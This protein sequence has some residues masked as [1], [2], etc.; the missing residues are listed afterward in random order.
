MNNRIRSSDGTI[1]CGAFS[2][3][4]ITGSPDHP[5][6]IRVLV[7][8]AELTSVAVE[9][10]SAIGATLTMMPGKITEQRLVEELTQHSTP[11]ILMRG[12]PPITRAVIEAAPAL[13]VIAK[14]GV[15]VDS[16]DLAAAKEK[17]IRVM[18]AGE[19]NAPAVA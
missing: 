13:R 1:S 9:T 17:G 2:D 18:V 16:V 3:H 5:M 15:G 8:G 12:N 10:L 4:P 7:T 14:H 19:A 6:R 11:A